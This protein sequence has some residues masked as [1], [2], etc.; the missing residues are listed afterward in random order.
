MS[1]KLINTKCGNL[2][3]LAPIPEEILSESADE[4]M[5]YMNDQIMS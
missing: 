4:S 2:N 3:V 1:L 5:L